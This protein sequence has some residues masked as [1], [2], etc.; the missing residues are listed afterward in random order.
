MVAAGMQMDFHQRLFR[1]RC[2]YRQYPVIQR[3][4]LRSRR[5]S[6]HHPG[7]VGLAIPQQEVCQL[8]FHFWQHAP[9]DSHVGFLHVGACCLGAQSCRSLFCPGQHHDAL[10]RLIQSMH[11]TDVRACALSCLPGTQQAFQIFFSHFLCLNGQTG[12]LV[13]HDDGVIR[14][15][16]QIFPAIHEWSHH[17]LNR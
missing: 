4:F 13:H 2:L 3:S 16:Q 10:H 1:F 15:Q 8:P 17:T 7:G 14:I 6:V 11:H 5:L 9:G 12:G